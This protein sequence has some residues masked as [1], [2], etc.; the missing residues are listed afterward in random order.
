RAT[1]I[2]DP[3]AFM[4]APAQGAICIETRVG[5]T[6]VKDLVSA[7]DDRDARVTV[8][9]ERAFLNLLDG[10][11]RTP[12]A[13][14]TR[15]EG[16]RIVMRGQ[17]LSPDGQQ[18]FEDAAEGDA[19]AAAV[20]GRR[21]GEILLAAAGPDFMAALKSR[22]WTGRCCSPGRRAPTTP[23][24]ARWKTPARACSRPHC[25]PKPCSI[26]KPATLRASA[27]LLSLPSVRRR[28]CAGSV[29][30]RAQSLFRSLLLEKLPRKR[31][32]ISGSPTCES[33]KRPGFRWRD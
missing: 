11:C 17:I 1:S 21:L 28:R 9:A 12:I 5:D 3:E 10:S 16:G 22:C 32:A 24:P 31:C 27:A 6:R 29:C 20:L 15:H 30:R 7:L 19:D 26:L 13:A 25:S 2:L 4:P 8:L 18:S 23:F 14:L 33:P